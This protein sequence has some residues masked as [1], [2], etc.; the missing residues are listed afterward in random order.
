MSARDSILNKVRASLKADPADETRQKAVA[1]RLKTAPFGVIPERGQV[2]GKARVSLFCDQAERA[3][4]TVERVSRREDVPRAIATYLRERNLPALI[5]MGSD[6]RLT[7]L[8]WD[9]QGALQIRN[10]VPDDDY[11][12]G[13]SHAFAAIAETGTLVLVSGQENPTS[14]NFLPEHHIVVV[15]ADD[16]RGDMEAALTKI[17]GRF[18]KGNM[19]RTVN[20][21]TGPSRSG[22]V[23]QKLI[24]GAHGPRALHLL[25][26][27]QP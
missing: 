11:D 19:P 14:V 27:G 17:R 7:T 15:D 6:E 24:L 13:V 9:K 12:C 3:F 20:F 25:V 16:I 26:V 22:D 23:E 8:P 10:D 21:I 1:Q 5:R 4:A 2:S 18:G